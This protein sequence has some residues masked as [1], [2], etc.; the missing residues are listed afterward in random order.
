MLALLL[1]LLLFRFA[2]LGVDWGRVGWRGLPEFSV[3]LQVAYHHSLVAARLQMLFSVLVTMMQTCLIAEV[4][5][6]NFAMR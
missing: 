5:E 2:V 3:L 1:R 4:Q 6:N